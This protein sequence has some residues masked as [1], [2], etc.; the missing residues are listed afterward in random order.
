MSSAGV[1]SPDRRTEGC[2]SV[3]WQTHILQ[4]REQ[5]RGPGMKT[6]IDIEEPDMAVLMWGTEAENEHDPANG[7][8]MAHGDP[9]RIVGLLDSIVA[10]A[11]DRP[12][13]ARP[14]VAMVSRAVREQLPERLLGWFG[15]HWGNDWDFFWTDAALR[16]RPG[17]DRVERIDDDALGTVRGVLARANPTS[18]AIPELETYRWFGIREQGVIA[19]VIGSRPGVNGRGDPYTYLGGLGTLPEYRGRGLGGALLA[20]VTAQDVETYGTVTFGMW[21]ENPARNL[22]EAL[23]FVHGGALVLASVEPLEAH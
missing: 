7:A 5:A 6:L 4:W 20:G 1:N 11:R 15:T 14:S 23:G 18:E 9:D 17:Q 3:F 10:S 8:F 16:E 12:S 2:G 13:L 22:Y 19:A 21:E